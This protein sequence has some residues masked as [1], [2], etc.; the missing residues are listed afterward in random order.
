MNQ[1]TTKIAFSPKLTQ[2]SRKDRYQA[3]AMPTSLPGLLSH[4]QQTRA[5]V[6]VSW[7]RLMLG[8]PRHREIWTRTEARRLHYRLPLRRYW[9]WRLIGSKRP[10][11]GLVS[12]P[13]GWCVDRRFKAAG[14]ASSQSGSAAGSHY[15][16]VAT[17]KD[18]PILTVPGPPFSV[19]L[20]LQLAGI[21]RFFIKLWV[22]KDQLH[23]RC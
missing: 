12:G 17:S 10:E 9:T 1:V 23:Y 2:R 20:L 19:F 21:T 18:V 8:Q 11:K 16:P 3:Q 13:E 22:V 15:D 6:T 4:H 7:G 14:S 5:P